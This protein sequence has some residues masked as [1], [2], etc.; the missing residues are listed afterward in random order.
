MYRTYF[1]AKPERSI[2][3]K[4]LRD[5]SFSLCYQMM[6]L[7]VFSSRYMVL[8]SY[9][10]MTWRLLEKL[11]LIFPYVVVLSFTFKNITILFEFFI[12]VYFYAK[13]QLSYQPKFNAFSFKLR[14]V[15][16]WRNIIFH[17]IPTSLMKPSFYLVLYVNDRAVVG[18]KKVL[19]CELLGAHIS[20]LSPCNMV[21]CRGFLF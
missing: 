9:I 19:K 4:S 11:I 1:S 18:W 5:I 17:W 6:F 7:L 21:R 16:F 8:S 2:Q 3:F 12:Q 14:N 10:S 15:A 20:E 13:Q